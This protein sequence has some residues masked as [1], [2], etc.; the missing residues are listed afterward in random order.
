M[1]MIDVSIVIPVY[2]ADRYI[3]NAI[4]SALSQKYINAE[5]IVVD[6]GCTDNTREVI[7]SYNDKVR[8]LYQ[9]NKGPAGARNLGIRASKSEY[10]AFLDADDVF[11][12]DDIV[13]KCI[14]L[15][16]EEK[17]AEIL[18]GKIQFQIEDVSRNF[19]LNQGEPIPNTG[20]GGLVCRKSVFDLIGLLDESLIIN[21]DLD[22]FF[23]VWEKGILTK[24]TNQTILFYRR[25]GQNITSVMSDYYSSIFLKLLHASIKRRQGMSFSFSD[26]FIGFENYGKKN[27]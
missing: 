9:E 3:S 5:I 7:S 13:Y 8:Y 15:L 18:L 22:W 17:K 25:H 20:F 4:D 12:D 2:N 21:E 27:N 19:F 11:F 10:L 1:S 24:F 23:R 26:V 6:D 16:N 14:H